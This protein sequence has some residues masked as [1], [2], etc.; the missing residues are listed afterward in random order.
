MAT[1]TSGTSEHY[2]ALEFDTVAG[3]FQ[4][5]AARAPERSAL[6]TLDGSVDISW[7][8][9]NDRVK[10]AA[11]GLAKLGV[12][13]GD[14]IAVMLVNRPEFHIADAAALHLGATAFSIYNTYTADQ[15]A[16][17]IEDGGPAVAVTEPQFLDRIQE[18]QGRDNAL[19][20][21]IVVDG[22]SPDGGMTLE[23]LEQHGDDDFDFD[24]V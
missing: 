17:L 12:G 3:A 5:T 18:V 15:I 9:Y 16:F 24:A 21:I 7:A 13:K 6:K 2:K 20:H 23:Q 8:E 14:T 19:E 22:E 11:A 4:F 1:Q 10:R